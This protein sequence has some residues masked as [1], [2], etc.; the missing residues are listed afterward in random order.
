MIHSRKQT[1]LV[2]ADLI[3]IVCM[4]ARTAQTPRTGTAAVGLGGLH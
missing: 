1:D 3:I 2:T 4:S